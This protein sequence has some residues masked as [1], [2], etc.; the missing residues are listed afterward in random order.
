MGYGDRIPRPELRQ[1]D[2]AA[3]TGS[4]RPQFS[5]RSARHTSAGYRLYR[6]GGHGDLPDGPGRGAIDSHGRHPH[7]E[8]PRKRG[9]HY[10]RGVLLSVSFGSDPRWHTYRR[11]AL[12]MAAVV[13][14]AFVLQF[15]TLHRGA[16]YGLA[17]RFFVAMLLAWLLTTSI[18][19]RA[20]LNHKSEA[21]RQ[22]FE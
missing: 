13:V 20:R 18:R 9:K 1:S 2:V 14:I 17:N 15:L 22:G 6:L 16:P 3:G 7:D 11:T 5:R 8:L 10:P 19:L 12:T 4:H 21:V